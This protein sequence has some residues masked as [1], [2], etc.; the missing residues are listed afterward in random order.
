[1]SFKLFK[2]VVTLI[3]SAVVSSVTKST[4]YSIP[5]KGSDPSTY[6]QCRNMSHPKRLVRSPFMENS[7]SA[8]AVMSF[9]MLGKRHRDEGDEGDRV[10]LW[11]SQIRV[12]VFLFLNGFFSYITFP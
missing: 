3:G 4:K 2:I 12:E 9:S 7:V 10:I 11:R 8:M 5:G 6:K 1:M